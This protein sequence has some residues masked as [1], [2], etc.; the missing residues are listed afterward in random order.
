MKY[1][2]HKTTEILIY[3]ILTLISNEITYATLESNIK[4]DDQLIN[5]NSIG[6]YKT[7]YD[8]KLLGIVFFND[9][10]FLSLKSFNENEMT[11]YVFSYK[12]DDEE[13][14]E[15]FSRLNHIDYLQFLG[16]W[17]ARYDELH[18]NSIQYLG[19]IKISKNIINRITWVKTQHLFDIEYRSITFLNHKDKIHVY[20]SSYIDENLALRRM[21]SF[22]KNEA[23]A[24]IIK[25]CKHMRREAFII[26]GG[27]TWKECMAKKETHEKIARVKKKFQEL[28]NKR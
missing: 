11:F 16:R 21:I 6:I 10:L 20:I 18:K 19:T 5:K 17:I 9:C 24:G 27:S 14:K 3:L 2:A 26:D 22:N 23:H 13:W 28:I 4:I 1:L 12:E 25:S 8:P 15:I 7:E